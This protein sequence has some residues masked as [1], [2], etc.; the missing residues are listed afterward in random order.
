MEP[1]YGISLYPGTGTFDGI[2]GDHLLL[3]PAY[4]VN[5]RDVRHIVNLTTKV[6]E[7][8]FHD[9]LDGQD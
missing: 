9:L 5:E 7:D 1:A 6:I 8:F 2:S 3:A 4:T